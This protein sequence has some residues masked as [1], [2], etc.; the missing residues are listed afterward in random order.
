[1]K[2]I[3]LITGLA[4]LLIGTTFSQQKKYIYPEVYGLFQKDENKTMPGIKN[5]MDIMQYPNLIVQNT[6]PLSAAD[7]IRRAYIMQGFNKMTGRYRLGYQMPCIKPK[8]YFP[9][10]IIKP[11]TTINYRL[12]VV[13]ADQ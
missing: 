2:R 4:G 5:D 8:G 1:M 6:M 7:R 11:D 12:I 13:D 10:V 9:S 3:I